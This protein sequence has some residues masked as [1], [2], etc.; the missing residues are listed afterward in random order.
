MK[1][2]KLFEEFGSLIM[3]RNAIITLFDSLVVGDV[4]LD[5]EGVEFI[6][7]S[8]AHEY[9]RQ[10]SSFT[11]QIKEINMGKDVKAMFVLVAKQLKKVVS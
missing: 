8:A 10:K 11:S 7:R 5:F 6:S 2:L 9:L 1:N 4:V 3:T